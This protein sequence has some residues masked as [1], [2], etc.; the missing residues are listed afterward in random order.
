[1]HFKNQ[2]KETLFVGLVKGPGYMHLVGEP[3]SY[4]QSHPHSLGNHGSHR[5]SLY[6]LA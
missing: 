6:A 4:L 2:I 1:M 3:A 5:K